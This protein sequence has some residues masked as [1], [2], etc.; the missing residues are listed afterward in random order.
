MKIHVIESGSK[1]NATL[2][3][4]DGRILLIDMGVSLSSLKEALEKLN[5]NIY[6]ID[7][8]LLTHSH[9]DHTKGIRYLPPLPIYCTKNSYDSSNIN[10]IK[11]YEPFVLNGVEILPIL[12]SHDGTGD[13]VGYILNNKR[14]KVVYL[15]DTGYVP[16][17][18]LK[19]MKNADYYVIES[20]H[21]LKM[22]Y[23]TNRPAEL[24]ARITGDFGHLSNEDSACY[25]VELVGDNTKEIILAHL[26]EE[27]N[28]PEVALKAYEK[29]FKKFHIS[30]DKV[31]IKCASQ[32]KM[33]E[34]G[35][36]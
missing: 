26:S 10:E 7:C 34:G 9:S 21:N 18:T 30:L 1:G 11:P 31:K 13:C 22:L 25:M 32:H 14:N 28:S 23:Q 33:V 29:K 2:I 8:L 6:D 20:N 12:A 27:A 24:K 5:K 4:N 16:E 19:L 17:E 3:E 15:T 36:L 35:N